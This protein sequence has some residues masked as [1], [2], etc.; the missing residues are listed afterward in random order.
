MRGDGY[1]PLLSTEQNISYSTHTEIPGIYKTTQ[2][3]P[4]AFA[5]YLHFLEALL[6]KAAL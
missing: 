1:G 2:R 6:L 5:L 3:T 4:T